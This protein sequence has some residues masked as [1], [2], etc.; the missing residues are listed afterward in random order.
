M[1]HL[2]SVNPRPYFCKKKYKYIHTSHCICSL[3]KIQTSFVICY[4]SLI[5][6]QKFVNFSR[7]SLPKVFVR[8]S[9]FIDALTI[10]LFCFYH[11]TENHT[12]KKHSQKTNTIVILLFHW[13]IKSNWCKMLPQQDIM[14]VNF[15]E[16]IIFLYDRCEIRCI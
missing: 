14:A 16:F 8:K 3:Q 13:D 9:Y 6:L 11:T 12:T 1:N 10:T 4:T 7:F 15:K 5:F 2:S